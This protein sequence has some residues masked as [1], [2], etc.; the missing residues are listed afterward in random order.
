MAAILSSTRLH[1][2]V[3]RVG[4]ERKFVMVGLVQLFMSVSLGSTQTS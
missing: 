3:S 1:R 2:G 4:K